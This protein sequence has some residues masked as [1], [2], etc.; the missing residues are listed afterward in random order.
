M[1]EQLI[2]PPE[3]VVKVF[4]VQPAEIRPGMVGGEQLTTKHDV[5]VQFMATTLGLTQHAEG[6]WQVIGN[7]VPRL[8]EA[9]DGCSAIKCGLG[10]VAL[11]NDTRRW[12]DC[13]AANT[14]PPFDGRPGFVMTPLSPDVV[15]L[16]DEG[17]YQPVTAKQPNGEQ[18]PFFQKVNTGSA[19]VISER[20][21]S[22]IPGSEEGIYVGLNLADSVVATQTLE[23]N[24]NRYAVVLYSSRENLGDRPEKFQIARNAVNGILDREGLTGDAR[25]EAIDKLTVQIDVGFSASL[26]NFAHKVRVPEIVLPDGM[27]AREALEIVAAE[28]RNKV[29]P[30]DRDKRLS[31]PTRYG[32]QL[33]EKNGLID[34]ETGELTGEVTPTQLMDDQYPGALESGEIHGGLEISRGIMDAPRRGPK[35]CPGHGE[36]CHIDYPKI[37]QRT[38][39]GELVALG[40]R[41]ENITYNNANAIDPSSRDN[42]LPSN[43]DLQL[44]DVAI[45]RTPRTVQGAV[46]KFP[47]RHTEQAE[48]PKA[49]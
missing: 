47:P 6:D 27:T 41:P 3:S 40:V 14:E 23:V 30:A 18:Q 15:F 43:R 2:L 10:E 46:I 24:G 8:C 26:K 29:K 5:E 25:A 42:M 45:I 20:D 31:G 37:N 17:A 32:L 48:E 39:T 13:A 49:A 19:L 16:G 1:T 7:T 28:N 12:I 9:A 34:A 22:K 11:K 44:E 36:L 21:M 33:A 35:G 4:G 38:R